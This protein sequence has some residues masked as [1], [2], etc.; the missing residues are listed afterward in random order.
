MINEVRNTVMAILNK[1]NNGYITPTE[2]NL[3]AKQAQLELFEEYFY[4][5]NNWLINQN[6]GN[7]RETRL[8]NS[9]YADIP[10]SYEQVIDSFS[11]TE[12]C[13]YATHQIDVTGTWNGTAFT[14]GETVT[15]A[16]SGATGVVTAFTVYSTVKTLRLTTVV[17]T[18]DTTNT[19]T[20]GSSGGTLATPMT[21]DTRADN[22]KL[23]D[24]WYYIN[25]IR[26][27]TSTEV[28]KISNNQI[29]LAAE[30]VFTAASLTYPNYYQQDEYLNVSPSDI[31]TQVT[32]H[33]IRYPKTP[34]WTYTALSA[35]DGDPVFNG[36]AND[37]QDFELPISDSTTLT[38]KI[39][40]YAGVNIREQEVVAFG[41]SEETVEDKIE[42]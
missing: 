6:Q 8:S 41:T 17:G 30:S 24:D 32:A 33:Y 7:G 38:F 31:I 23:P 16:T 18:F 39:L 1:D 14:V 20:G 28:E 3:F 2:F 13:P 4:D 21:V 10:Q 36:G 5:Y 27:A 12:A 22:F 11:T 15:Q 37:Y 25:F 19:I 29:L 40:Q 35:S 9:G 42:S 26:Y 34:N